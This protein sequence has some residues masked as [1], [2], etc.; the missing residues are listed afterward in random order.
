MQEILKFIYFI[1]DEKVKIFLLYFSGNEHIIHI[2]E[3][4]DFGSLLRGSNHPR[5]VK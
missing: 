1:K 5:K 4:G 3:Q 2:L